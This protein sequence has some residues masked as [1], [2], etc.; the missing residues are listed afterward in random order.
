MA[1]MG[2]LS[3]EQK[4][5]WI[6]SWRSHSWWCGLYQKANYKQ[7]SSRVYSRTCPVH[8]LYQGPLRG[9]E[10]TV[11][12]FKGW[13]SR[14][15]LYHPA[16]QANKKPSETHKGEMHSPIHKWH[17]VICEKA[18]DKTK[19]GH[20]HA[21]RVRS[22]INWKGGFRFDLRKKNVQPE[23]KHW[24]RGLENLCRFSPCRLSRPK[25]TKP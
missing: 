9:D 17:R 7:S 10:C 24:H 14:V 4:T 22:A 5:G 12:K 16:R 3:A 25:T 2:G 8:Y 1:W 11:L 21:R 15:S 19:A 18:T 6:I 20:M 13:C 23:D